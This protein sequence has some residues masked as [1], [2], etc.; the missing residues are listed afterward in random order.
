MTSSPVFTS[1]P[2]QIVQSF[3]DAFAR[4]DVKAAVAAADGAPAAWRNADGSRARWCRPGGSRSRE[5]VLWRLHF[6]VEDLAGGALGQLADEP[7]MARV[8]VCRHPF[9][10]ERAQ[11]RRSGCR[12]G[13]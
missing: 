5:E 11:F 6:A 4:H 12:S 13:F 3:L 7:D 10:G 1:T 9:P 2:A 8:L